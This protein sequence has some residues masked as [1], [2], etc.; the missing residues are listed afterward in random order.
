MRIN[1]VFDFTRLVLNRLLHEGVKVIVPRLGLLVTFA[2][3]VKEFTEP[4]FLPIDLGCADSGLVE[5][6]LTHLSVLFVVSFVGS[7]VR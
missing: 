6:H 2:H 7:E 1:L 3:K 5:A 4:L